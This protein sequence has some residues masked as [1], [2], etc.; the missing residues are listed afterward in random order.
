MLV[1]ESIIKR[2]NKISQKSTIPLDEILLACDL[3]MD[4]TFFQFNNK[5]YKQLFGTPMGSPISGL[6]ADIVMDDLETN[7]LSQLSFQPTFFHRYV[8]DIITCIPKNKTNEII[9]TFNTY[10]QRLQFTYETEKDESIN[11]LDIL[12]IKHN[13]KIITNWY[14]KPT[15]SG[16][17][18]NYNSHHPMSQKIAMIYNLVDR[19][20]KLSD[21]KFH[22][23]NLKHVKKLLHD[24]GYPKDF[25]YKYIFKRQSAIQTTNRPKININR[26]NIVCLP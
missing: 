11:F 1:K 21:K 7:C 3:I 13:N 5:F 23:N 10:N 15:S 9:N 8:D 17:F 22:Y 4:N 19:A 2:Y 12:L 18:L 25:T 14:M 26:E 16:R 24:N 20:I 6:F